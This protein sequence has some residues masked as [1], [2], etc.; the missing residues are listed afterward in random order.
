MV[1]TD[2]GVPAVEVVGQGRARATKTGVR[3]APTRPGCYVFRDADDAVLYIGKSIAL[4]TRLASYFLPRQDGKTRAMLRHARHVEW[5]Q[6]A[7][8]VEALILESQLIKRHQPPYNVM[9]REYPHYSFVRLNDG[10]GFPYLELTSGVEADGAAYFG[11]FWGKRSAEQT[12]DF[13]NRL[14]SLR[15][16]VGPLPSRAV[17]SACFYAQTHKCSAPCLGLTTGAA[18]GQQV[19]SAADL[20]RGDLLK[21]VGRL[22]RERDGAAE[23]LRFEQAAELQR[24]IVTLQSLQRKRRHLRSAANTTNFLVVVRRPDSTE[25]QVLAFSA[26]RLRGQMV[27]SG[28]VDAGV[29]PALQRFVAEHYPVRRELAIDLDELD[30][31]E[32]VADW[33][34]RQGR[35]AAYIPLPDGP[36]SAQG[37]R[38]AVS[39]VAQ[40][41]AD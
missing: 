7:S 24:T 1:Q 16:C 19:R 25:A 33:L 15:R 34:G 18:Y 39:A 13:A 2:A 21:L 31:M 37:A 40:I 36:I 30:Q 12:A 29:A 32:V 38:R 41:L 17:G 6:V 27:V 26:A 20:L 11:P 5:L 35:R 23:Q 22:E 10:G 4:R 14:F 8:E 9:L 28:A 3:G